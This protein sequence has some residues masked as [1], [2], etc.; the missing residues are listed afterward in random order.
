MRALIVGCG[1]VGGA[2]ADSLAADGHQVV[3]TTT[4]PGRVEELSARCTEVRVLRGSDAAAV[5]DAAAGCDAVVVAAGPA[6]ARAMTAEERAATYQEVLVE[7]ATSVVA[8]VRAGG[9]TGPVVSLSS[10]SVYGRAADGLDRIDEDAPLTASEDA[11]PRFFQAMERAYLDGL[12]GQA[13]VLRCA[14]VYGEGDMPVEDKIRMAH[15]VLKGSVPFRGDALFYRVH[16]ADV[17]AAARHAVEAGLA[18][19]FNLTHAE[20]PPTNRAYFDAIGAGMGFGPL[21]FRDEIET[22]ARPISIDRLLATG[23]TPSATTPAAA[24]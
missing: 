10:L 3:G 5:A 15:T 11:S 6:A 21:V 14:D 20:A 13:C 2:L 1:L 23:F 24:G 4:T 9:V 8:A 7:T 17:V 18:G 19:V 22:P 16:V 12:P